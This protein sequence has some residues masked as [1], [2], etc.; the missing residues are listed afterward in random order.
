M[1]NEETAPENPSEENQENIVEQVAKE[2]D[3]T[4]VFE[5][6]EHILDEI[7]PMS[8]RQFRFPKTRRS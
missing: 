8:R 7:F 6:A 4:L 1:K 2:E 3:L 5:D